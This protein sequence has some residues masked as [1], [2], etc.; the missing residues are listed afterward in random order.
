MDIEID[1]F[2][3]LLIMNYGVTWTN[4]KLHFL[5]F[6]LGRI[7]NYIMNTVVHLIV[8]VA[9]L[10]LGCAQAHNNIGCFVP[11]QCEGGVSVG[12]RNTDTPVDCLDFCTS[13]PDC[14]MFTHYGDSNYCIGYANC[15]ATNDDC[16]DCISGKFETNRTAPKCVQH[17]VLVPGAH[18][19]PI[20]FAIF[21]SGRH[22][23]Y[24]LWAT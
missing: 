10:L 19:W 3:E 1:V 23:T 16:S 2:L 17:R 22:R 12:I 13:I 24:V 21:A 5:L 18:L 15:P 8:I 7:M 20:L 11:V 6:I 9:L 14:L 4:W